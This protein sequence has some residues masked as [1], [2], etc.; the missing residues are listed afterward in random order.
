M[1][2]PTGPK[3]AGLDLLIGVGSRG[4]RRRAVEEALRT[5]I[6][7]G[8]L[9]AGSRLPSTRDLAQQLGLARGTVTQA[10]EQLIAEGWL[11]A[12]TKAGT[13]VAEGAADSAA[14][15]ASLPGASPVRPASPLAAS[16]PR[17]DFSPGR[18]DLSS[19][20]RSAWARAQRRAIQE[21]PA[22]AFGYGD[23]RGHLECRTALAGYLGRVRGVRVP[24]ERLLICSGY[25]QALGLLTGVLA[26]LGVTRIGMEDPAMPEHVAIA[27][28]HLEV[29]D[30]PV[31]DEGM[32]VSTLRGADVQAVV[33]TPAHQ[34]PLGVSMSPARRAGLLAWADATGGW[35]IEDDYDGEFRYD[36]QPVGAIQPHRPERVVYAG[37][38]SKSLGPAVRLGWIACPPPLLE[39]LVEAKNLQ[40]RQ[41]APLDQLALARL[42]ASGAYD[43]HVRTMRRVY[44]RRRDLL[45]AAVAERL[46]EARVTGIAAGMHAVMELPLALGPEPRITAALRRASVRARTLSE[47]Q[48]GQRTP[49]ALIVGY[50]TPRGHAYNGALAALLGA[51]S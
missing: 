13:R 18:P 46:P 38:V 48:R 51:F 14:A 42:L 44:R 39:P 33:C 17:H 5:A 16:A 50:A 28:A 11:T 25:T 29:C 1:A 21:A 41:T 8:R 23:P 49:A 34:F 30:A 10:Y 43:H 2:D 6:R 9:A 47:Y 24:P 12:R 40:D 7:E 37:S 32:R 27:S 26:S 19:F 20:P 22:E 3:D 15:A 4:S 31:D 45:T 35:I 36:R